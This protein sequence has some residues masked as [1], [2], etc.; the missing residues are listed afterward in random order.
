M[1]CYQVTTM[2]TKGL[3]PVEKL[4]VLILI[5]FQFRLCLILVIYECDAMKSKPKS[6]L[7]L[8][9]IR[10]R[11]IMQGQSKNKFRYCCSIKSE[12][13]PHIQYMLQVLNLKCCFNE[14]TKF[15][16]LWF[17]FFIDLLYIFFLFLL[18]LPFYASSFTTLN[19]NVRYFRE[20]CHQES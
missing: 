9:I 1:I 6:R 11:S 10:K 20:K 19:E 5:I 13:K 17:S 4:E 15:N 3:R 2:K 8:K 7:K 18:F 12:M 16:V 14:K